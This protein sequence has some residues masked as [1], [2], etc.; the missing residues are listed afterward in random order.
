MGK[1]ER[2]NIRISDAV[3]SHLAELEAD[4]ITEGK[5]TGI[6]PMTK[7][8]IVVQAIEQY[9]AAKK[10]KSTGDAT[11]NFMDARIRKA[12]EEYMLP[13]GA[14]LDQA[15]RMLIQTILMWRLQFAETEL[16][17]NNDLVDR[18]IVQNPYYESQGMEM[19][20][21]ILKQIKGE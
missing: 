15:M 6:P 10:N 9:Y 3:A 19:A 12:L 18:L 4:S 17:K 8:D 14:E 2:I 7:S 1:Q 20:K 16:D 21:K 11:L 13:F 5:V